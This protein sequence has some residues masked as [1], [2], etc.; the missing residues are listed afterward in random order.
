MECYLSNIYFRDVNKIRSE[1]RNVSF[2]LNFH[3]LNDWNTF[4]SEEMITSKIVG[5]LT[6]QKKKKKKE[7]KSV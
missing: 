3:K 7:G 4:L 1:R 2:K 6:Y 5:K